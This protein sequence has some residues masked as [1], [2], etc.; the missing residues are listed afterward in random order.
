MA[1]EL[2]LFK[3]HFS[4]QFKQ[5]IHTN[6][7]RLCWADSKGLCIYLYHKMLSGLSP[8]S[9]SSMCF[10]CHLVQKDAAKRAFEPSPHLRWTFFI[11]SADIQIP[12]QLQ[13]NETT[14]MLPA[15]SF[16]SQ[17]AVSHRSTWELI[18]TREYILE[19]MILKRHLHSRT[20]EVYVSVSTNFPWL[21]NNQRM[22]L[23][24]ESSLVFF[25]FGICQG[26]MFT[27]FRLNHSIK[28]STW[29]G[30]GRRRRPCSV[31]YNVLKA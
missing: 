22:I 10:F 29:S 8:Y 25:F 17:S 31:P 3:M 21:I 1:W 16:H 24:T 12:L 15:C 2:A 19:T 18:H 4:A 9:S 7:Y 20:C 28:N 13:S 11:R 30:T 26:A 27:F 6:I 14:Q 5:Y 23:Y